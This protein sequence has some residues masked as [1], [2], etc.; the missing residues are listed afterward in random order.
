VRTVQFN[1]SFRVGEQVATPAGTLTV[2]TNGITHVNDLQAAWLADADFIAPEIDLARV[3]IEQ[4][5]VA[6]VVAEA[7]RQSAI[8]AN[9]AQGDALAQAA[10]RLPEN[11]RATR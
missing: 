10:R 5:N 6:H 1:R 11:L 8:D 3:D 7:E 4:I 9:Q 2:G